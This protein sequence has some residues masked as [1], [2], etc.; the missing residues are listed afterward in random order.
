M[1]SSLYDHMVR[2]GIVDLLTSVIVIAFGIA[3]SI[4]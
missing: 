4:L 2:R 3:M 1:T